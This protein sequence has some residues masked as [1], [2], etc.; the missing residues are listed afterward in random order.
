MK[1][2][3]Q[4]KH[5]VL[6]ELEWEPAI[7]GSKIGVE[8]KEGVVILAGHVDSLVDK[9][10]AERAS[11][12]IAGVKAVAVALDVK[13]PLAQTRI[14]ADIAPS[15]TNIL[16]WMTSLPPDAVKV[17][18][19]HGWIT[20]TGDVAW[21]YQKQA[22]A[23]SIRYLVGLAGITND[24]AID[25]TSIGAIRSDVESAL[26]RSRWP[27]RKAISVDVRDAEVTLSGCVRSWEERE[28]AVR[29]A[30]SA[31]GVHH[32]VNNISLGD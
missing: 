9:W 28:S 7:Q 21:Q 5:D 24:I 29:P 26:G 25:P 6:A 14:D 4:L 10:N 15:A 13:V 31:R 2:D 30:W 32:V 18:V 27:H 19:E 11:R 20:L 8:V 23:D 17:M 3:E 22:A 16:E 1:S 12:R